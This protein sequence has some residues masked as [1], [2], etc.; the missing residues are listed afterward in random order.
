MKR[1]KRKLPLRVF[2]AAGFLVF[3]TLLLIVLWMF[4][5]VFLETF[6]KTVKTRQVKSCAYSVADN[7]EAAALSDLITDI[8]EQNTMSV[9]IFDTESNIFT[10]VY[11]SKN[12]AQRFTLEMSAVYE[13]Y[14]R[15]GENSG[16]YSTVTKSSNKRRFDQF[17]ALETISPDVATPDSAR[18]SFG[19]FNDGDQN[20]DQN[21][22]RSGEQNNSDRSDQ[23]SRTFD[24][25]RK[26]PV[27]ERERME[28]LAFAKVVS[29]SS[30]ERLIVVV[31]EITPV[32]SVVDTLRYQ[33]IIMTAVLIA[34]SVT[35]AVFVAKWIAKPIS[36]TNEKA[37]ALA[38]RDYDLR[39]SGG[40]YREIKELN[41]TLSYAALELKKVDNLQKELIA[42]ISHD[43]RTPLTMITGYS[44]I[45]RDLPGEVTP[46]NIQIIIDEATRLND[47]VSDLLDIS[48]LQSGTADIKRE[49]FSLT[50]CI[51]SIFSRYTKLIESEGLNLVFEHDREVFVM[52]DEL[53]MTQVIYNLI[54]NAINYIG[55]DKTV[56]V[57]QTVTDDRV[58]I[59]VI[60]HGEGIPQEK[61]E[62]I[63]DRYYRVDKEHRRAVIGT[64]LGLS[65]VKNILIAHD[66]DFGVASKL[67]EGSD[68]YFTMPIIPTD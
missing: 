36:D 32:S 57:R 21:S 9:A 55:E 60:D 24:E 48:R 51:T 64:G 29:S 14:Q 7:I 49:P 8:E 6:Y 13:L 45:M 58:K 37:K 65:I 22:T 56:L 31:S 19:G 44:E 41:D 39:F 2:L 20:G 4:Q 5:T 53:R 62:F 63:W 25:D 54:N 43:L 12:P 17:A 34:L 61:L 27:L 52:G 50:G 1:S 15:A 46:E 38:D 16:E 40:R 3:S 26:F 66:A 10:T 23:D 11:S 47:L 35:V 67:G 28:T 68:F 59:E 33:L 30:G 42:N 18:W